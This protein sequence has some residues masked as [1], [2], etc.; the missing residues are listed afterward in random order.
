[1]SEKRFFEMWM[2]NI[3]NPVNHNLNYYNNYIGELD[4]FQMGKG[5][6]TV[7][8]FNFFAFTGAKEEKTSYGVSVKEV[9]PKS[10]SPQDLNQASSEIQRVTVEL[11]YREWHTIKEEG[12][13]DSIADKSLRLRGS[14][15]YIGDDSRYS[16]ISPKGV[17]YDILGK[18][19]ASP[20]AIAT[21]GSAADIITGGVG[22]TI[23]K[24]VR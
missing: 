18:S 4:I 15:I 12:V 14:D 23:G 21:A 2:K 13:D 17:L 5:S 8:P 9:W 3:Y 1:M 22:N 19:G 6:N 20:T 24:F 10:I 7:I 16:I 11:A